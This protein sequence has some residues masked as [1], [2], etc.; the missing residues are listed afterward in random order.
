M[1]KIYTF[2]EK[3]D[4]KE[5]MKKLLF[6]LLILF[7][8]FSILSCS[9]KEKDNTSLYGPEI[10]LLDFRGKVV[11]LDF[12]AEWCGPCKASTPI[13]EKIYNEY[14][15]KDFIVIGMNLDDES[16]FNKVI[17]Y[18]KTNRIEYPITINGFSVAKKYDVSGIPRFVL[19][20][21]EGKIALIKVGYDPSLYDLFKEA[22]EYL[23]VEGEAVKTKPESIISKEQRKYAPDFKLP[24]LKF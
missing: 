4:K 1:G 20:D 7:L 3:G 9:K 18:V 21:K 22:I 13:I 24:T 23:L 6:I 10:S 2:E 15:D 12:W 16:D 8:V 11:L 19:I 17:N 5:E 14:K